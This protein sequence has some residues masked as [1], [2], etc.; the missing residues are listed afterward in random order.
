MEL[1]IQDKQTE[2]NVDDFIEKHNKVSEYIK[3][4]TDIEN[5]YQMPKIKNN[6]E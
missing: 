5:I 3:Q 1:E 4:Y 2:E 6:N